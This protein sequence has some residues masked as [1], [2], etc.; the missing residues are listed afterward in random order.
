MTPKTYRF[1]LHT[2]MILSVALTS[3]LIIFLEMAA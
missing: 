2:L 1:T 3:V